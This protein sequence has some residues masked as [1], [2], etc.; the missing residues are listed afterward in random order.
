MKNKFLT[1]LQQLQALSSLGGRYSM[2]YDKILRN[3]K[4]LLANFEALFGV[5][6]HLDSRLV[7]TLNSVLAKILLVPISLFLC[8]ERFRAQS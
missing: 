1:V 2:P 4:R 8:N 7:F 5:R 6:L 3:F